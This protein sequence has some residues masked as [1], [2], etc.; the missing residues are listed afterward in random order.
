MYKYTIVQKILKS[1][2]RASLGEFFQTLF[3]LALLERNIFCIYQQYR[4]IGFRI[5][6]G[7]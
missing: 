1:F 3:K 4:K 2:N 7:L 6:E 5:E